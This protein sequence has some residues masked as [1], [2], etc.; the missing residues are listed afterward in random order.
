MKVKLSI[1]F[2]LVI[3]STFLFAQET[4][5]PDDN[6]EAF[7]EANGMGNGIP[8]DDYVTTSNIST[9]TSLD[10]SSSM[11]ADITGI[12][13]FTALEVLDFSN[14]GVGNFDL[15]NNIAL[16]ELYCATNGMSSINVAANVN[17]E[18]LNCSDNSN[19]TIDIST[20]IKLKELNI[21]TNGTTSLNLGSVSTLEIINA[22][23]NNLTT[24]DL[25]NLSNLTDLN[26]DTNYTLDVTDFSPLTSLVNLNFSNTNLRSLNL[27]SNTLLETLTIDFMSGFYLDLS[28]NTALTSISANSSDLNS[29]NIKNGNNANITSFDARFN[30]FTCISV[31]DPTA[32]Y[33]S[34]WQKDNKA[35]FESD[36]STTNIIDT[37]FEYHLE[38]HDAD[39]NVVSVGSP[40]SMGN[41]IL[42]DG[43]VFTSRIENVT[44]LNISGNSIDELDGLEAFESLEI[45]DCSENNFNEFDFSQLP[46][47]KELYIHDLF[48]AVLNLSSNLKIEKLIY[49]NANSTTLNLGNNTVIKELNIGGNNITSFD[50]FAY[51]TIE[52]LNIDDNY[53]ILPLNVRPL[54]NLKDLSANN[55]SLQNLDVSQNVLLEKLSIDRAS[56][57]HLDLSNNTALTSF[58]A[59]CKR[60]MVFP[61][62]GGPTNKTPLGIFAPTAV[63]FS[64]CLRKVITS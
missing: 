45:L 24:L 43:K 12:E 10:I 32:S 21:S 20:N 51:T 52:V 60:V 50:V 40:N 16:K 9:V 11:I 4:Y 46:E 57:F 25:T 44:Y 61:E 38:N 59:N 1:V 19:T 42:N 53:Q 17:L 7:L 27:S 39:G 55:T 49:N 5:V 14:N 8:N 28:S 37:N 31:D 36:C 3:S 41:G 47:L 30:Q 26:C 35:S 22:S 2:F 54:T 64:G 34:T 13:D 29:L 58:S 56:G 48:F 18:V 15:S 6:F 23:N 63:N 33:L 62:P